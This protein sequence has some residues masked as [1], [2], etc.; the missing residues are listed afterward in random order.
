MEMLLK[1]HSIEQMSRSETESHASNLAEAI[2]ERMQDM[3]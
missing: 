2:Q 3:L 1:E